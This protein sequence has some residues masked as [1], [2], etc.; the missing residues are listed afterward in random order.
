MI[1]TALYVV[2]GG[3]GALQLAN[4]AVVSGRL[5]HA[6]LD[7]RGQGV[8]RVLGARQLAQALASGPAPGYPVLAVGAEVDLLHAASMVALA[9]VGRH[10][11]PALT[12]ALIAAAF[13]L[14][15]ALACR[16]AANHPPQPGNAVRDLRRKWADRVATACVPGYPEH[17][18]GARSAVGTI[19]GR[20][21]AGPVCPTCPNPKR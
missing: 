11:R 8:A 10:R 2:R 1:R 20:I 5:L 14:A 3:Y 13:A 6:D 17:P 18:A 12:D 15:G 7:A 16:E 9:A 21:Y 19:P 4:P